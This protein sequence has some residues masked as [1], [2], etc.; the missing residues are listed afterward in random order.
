VT[1]S[2]SYIAHQPSPDPTVWTCWIHSESSI[3]IKFF[4]ILLLFFHICLSL[5]R[6]LFPCVPPWCPRDLR[7]SATSLTWSPNNISEKHK[8]G[9]F[10][11]CN[12]CMV[13]LLFLS[14]RRNNL[15]GSSFR[16]VR[17]TAKGDLAPLC[18]SVRTH[19]TAWLPLDGFSWNLIFE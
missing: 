16:R 1:G 18:L 2:L 13:V 9:S 12:L 7:H 14:L 4:K 5:A 11:F 19:R 3:L 10:L 8:F 15:L 17:K 6:G